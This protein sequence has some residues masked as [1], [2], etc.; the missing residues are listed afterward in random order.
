MISSI[1]TRVIGAFFK[2]PL[3]AM[4]GG[5]GMGYFMTAYTVIGPALSMSM[6]GFSISV[7]KLTAASYGKSREKDR[8]KI[9]YSAI[10]LFTSIGAFLAIIIYAA[11]PAFLKAAGNQ[12]AEKAAKAMIPSIIF[13]CITSVFRG[14][15][16]GVGDMVPTALSQVVEAIIK[17]IIGMLFSQLSVN[18]VIKEF[19]QFGTAMGISA[20]NLSEAISIAS[21][22]TA[23][24]AV[25]GVSVSTAVGSLVMISIFLKS[26]ISKTKNYDKALNF[27]MISSQLIRTALP[28]SAATLVINVVAIVDT[29]SI[30]NILNKSAELNWKALLLSH[31]ELSMSGINIDKAANFLYG[32]YTGLAMTVFNIAPA[33]TASLGVCA[34]PMISALYAAR[35]RTILRKRIESI[36]RI[37]FIA[38]IP[39]GLGMSTM[40]EPIIKVLFPTNIYEAPIAADLLKILGIASIFVSVSVVLNNILQAVG[41]IFAP[42]KLLLVGSIIKISVN[43]LLISVPLINISGAPWG[44]LICYLFI[45]SAGIWVLMQE[46]DADIALLPIIIKPAL[47]SLFCCASAKYAMKIMEKLIPYTV[48]MFVSIMI[49]AIIYIV[50]L[51]ILKG[52]DQSELELLGNNS[53][54]NKLLDFCRLISCKSHCNAVK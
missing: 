43:W 26:G 8:N 20:D 35:N 48:S 27:T 14:Y 7:S 32:S 4:L 42:L 41:R 44:T 9:L 51:V 31:P 28:V 24:A 53:K 25:S 21:P 19:E 36:L 22:T 18:K 33:F 1:I 15:Y 37:T 45:M 23:A 3:A 47:A 49:G 38:A 30:V 46:I 54:L 16:E 13:C 29:F 11:V 5:E 39:I 12:P 40:A 50:F 17:L 34:L 2:I 6:L 10:I 52:F